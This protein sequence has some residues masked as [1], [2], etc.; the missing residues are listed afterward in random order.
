MLPP[1]AVQALLGFLAAVGMLE[2]P[3]TAAVVAAL[4]A[5]ALCLALLFLE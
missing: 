5:A 3:L 2:V 4:V 1:L